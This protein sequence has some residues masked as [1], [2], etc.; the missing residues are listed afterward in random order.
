MAALRRH[1]GHRQFLPVKGSTGM[2][3]KERPFP[4]MR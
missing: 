4:P 2:A 3:G 1:P